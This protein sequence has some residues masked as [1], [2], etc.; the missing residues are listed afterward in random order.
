MPDRPGTVAYVLKGFPR[1]SE[2]FVASEIYRL[3]Q[4]G[5]P[6]APLRAQGVR[7]SPS[8]TAS[9]TSS[10]PSPST[11]PRPTILTDSA[12]AALAARQRA[13]VPRAAGP[14]GPTP[15]RRVRPVRRAGD[16]PGRARPPTSAVPAPG[17]L[18]QGVAV[19]GRAG[20]P[21]AHRRGRAPPA[22]ALRAR[23][24]DRRL[25]RGHDHRAA[26]LVHR[27]R[28]GPLHRGAQPGRGLL[29]RKTAAARFVVT[30]TGANR[31]HLLRLGTATPVHVVQHGL[32]T[33]FT[34]LVGDALDR[35]PPL[36]PDPP[37]RRAARAEEGVRH[38]RRGLR[39]AAS[40]GCGVH[41]HDRR[42]TRTRTATRSRHSSSGTGW[43]TRSSVVGPQSAGGP[44][45]AVPPRDP[46]VARLPGHRRRRPRRHPERARRGDGVRHPGGEHDGVRHPRA[47]RG[48]RDRAARAARTT[49]RRWPPPGAGWPTTP[50]LAARLGDA[51][52]RT[53]LERFDGDVLAARLAG[54]LAVPVRPA[55]VP[56]G[57][58]R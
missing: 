28:E 7:T 13:T 37:G 43:A 17:H 51:G 21:R 26:V 56:T 47:R 20:R 46:H 27:P 24:H 4:L 14:G 54:L 9:S 41:R 25:A 16:R 38:V 42:R 31:E 36:D 53:V 48:R 32:S 18:R 57:G 35:V 23:Q 22:R 29:A 10:G 45:R 34:D 2:T 52:R 50:T 49:R 39:R 6:L 11:C 15:P 44:V 3:E 55:A 19:R 40:R 12:A 1:I 5:V 33:D 58:R 8:S 30:C